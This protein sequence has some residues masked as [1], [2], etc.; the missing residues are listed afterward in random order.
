M[1][2]RPQLRS[3]LRALLQA[4]EQGAA[5]YTTINPWNARR[6]FAL[7]AYLAEQYGYRYAGLSPDH[8]PSRGH[9]VF[10]FRRLPDAAERATRTRARYP[11]GPLG[12]PLP[13][14][15]P[16]RKPAPLPE[17]R[18]E[19]EL[20]HARIKVDLYGTS[21]NRRLRMLAVAVPLGVLIALAVNGSLEPVPL[22]VA[23]GIAAVWWLY[24]WLAAAIMRRGRRRYGRMLEQAGVE[25][26]PGGTPG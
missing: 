11:D 18:Q 14:L 5:T 3:Q 20:L 16:G 9:P 2:L 1:S 19:V 10:A 22:A 17:A 4:G 6:T 24:L 25:W 13:G 26:P 15:T 21:S 7:F 12:G 8:S 23:G